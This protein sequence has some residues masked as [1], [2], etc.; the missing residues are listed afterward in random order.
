[1]KYCFMLDQLQGDGQEDSES[2]VQGVIVVHNEIKNERLWPLT[3]KW[4]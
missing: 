1:M 3:A 2:T 4:N